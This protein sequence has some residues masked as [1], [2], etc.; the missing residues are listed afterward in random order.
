[1]NFPKLNIFVAWFLIPQ[2]LA[3]G[4][5]AFVGRMVLE[6]LGVSTPEGSVPGILVGMVMLCAV[7]FVVQQLRGA[8]WPVGVPDGNGYLLGQRL[9]LAANILAVLILAFRLAGHLVGNRDLAMLLDKFTDAFG[10]WVMG[11]WAIGFSFLYQSS[12]PAKVKA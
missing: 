3:L 4:W 5:V 8:L 2:T 12:L 6:V 10:Y 7:V 11:M 9:T 1:M